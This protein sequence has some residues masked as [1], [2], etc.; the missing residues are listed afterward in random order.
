MKAFQK[1]VDLHGPVRGGDGY[2]VEMGTW[3]RW[4]SEFTRPQIRIYRALHTVSEMLYFFT[5][6]DKD[7]CIQ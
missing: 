1:G 5:G 6:P 4:A 7:T 3:W 2:V